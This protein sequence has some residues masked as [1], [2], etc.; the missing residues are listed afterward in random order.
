MAGSSIFT[1]LSCSSTNVRA[2]SS[3]SLRVRAP[4]TGGGGGALI[5]GGL[6]RYPRISSSWCEIPLV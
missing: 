1:R 5:V 3:S 6:K 4:S 2:N